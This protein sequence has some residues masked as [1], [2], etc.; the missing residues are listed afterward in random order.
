[1]MR[2]LQNLYFASVLIA[3]GCKTNQRICS[4]LKPAT[5]DLD[6]KIRSL[7]TE[8]EANFTAQSVKYISTRDALY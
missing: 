3:G 7:S 4:E 5:E 1:M 2:L 8:Y 6:K